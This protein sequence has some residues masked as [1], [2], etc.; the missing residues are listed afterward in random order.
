MA[1]FFSQRYH[2]LKPLF[3][4]ILVM[5][6]VQVI[7]SMTGDA[8]LSLG[9]L[10]RS[11][12]GIWGILF[13][14]FLHADWG[15]LLN[16]LMIFIPLSILLC[17]RSPK[18]YWLASAFIIIGSGI[19]MWLFARTAYHIGA[20]GWVFGLWGLILA[21][22]WFRRSFIDLAFGVIVLIYF[23]SIASG[24]LPANGISFE[25]H[26]FGVVWGVLYAWFSSKSAKKV[27][28]H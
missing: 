10:P 22:A 12:S 18:E 20:S 25:G 15:H 9:L 8:L 11:F 24:L 4:V 16:N 3:I 5:I 2:Q 1:S 26:I 6:G 14:P 27:A 23:G 17:L 21:N 28:D 13:S 19:S 7:N